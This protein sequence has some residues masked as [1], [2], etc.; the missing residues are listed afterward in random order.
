MSEEVKASLKDILDAINGI[1]LHLDEKYDFTIYK[2]NRTV[3]RAVEREPEIIGEAV[4]RILKAS[5]EIE[6]TSARKI[7]DLRN[8]VAHGYDIVI[9]ENIW[10]IVVNHIPKLKVE[11]ERLLAQDR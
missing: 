10:A 4:S 6:I 7:I 1:N 5:A 3:R 8:V 9:D 11:V 2:S